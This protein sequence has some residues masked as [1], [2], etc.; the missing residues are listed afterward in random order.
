MTLGASTPT[1]SRTAIATFASVR[2][3]ATTTTATLGV[4]QATQA[5]AS[6][7]HGATITIWPGSGGH[8][9]LSASYVAS[10]R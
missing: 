7:A 2:S 8:L 1:T 6:T 4:A 5:I 3:A 10:S 9:H